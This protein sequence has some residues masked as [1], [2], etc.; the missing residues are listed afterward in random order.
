MRSKGDCIA[1]IGSMNNPYRPY[2]IIMISN[3]WPSTLRRLAKVLGLLAQR[4]LDYLTLLG[5]TKYTF[6]N[7]E[8][9]GF[10]DFEIWMRDFYI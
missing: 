10:M 6:S 1:S 7:N 3:A 5:Q 2:S 4:Y 9:T 8:R